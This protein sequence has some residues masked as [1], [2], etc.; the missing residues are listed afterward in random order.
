MKS[1]DKTEDSYGIDFNDIWL[2]CIDKNGLKL[3]DKIIGG[4][5][6]DKVVD[7]FY[8]NQSKIYQLIGLSSSPISFDKKTS[9][10]STGKIR[11]DYWIVNFSYEIKD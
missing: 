10:I 3:W 1:G 9:E 8:D 6:E 7:I 11:D 5:Y 4:K 2:V